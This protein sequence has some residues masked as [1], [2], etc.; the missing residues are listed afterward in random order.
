VPRLSET[1]EI[2]L[3]EQRSNFNYENKILASV[4]NL[5]KLTKALAAAKNNKR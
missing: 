3:E 4:L 5:M 2:S 1:K